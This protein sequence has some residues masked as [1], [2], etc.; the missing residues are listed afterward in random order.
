MKDEFTI[1]AT[2]DDLSTLHKLAVEQM[3]L[4]NEVEK[5]EKELKDVK[6]ELMK[7]QQGFLPDAIQNC[8]LSEFKT[9]RGDIVTVKDDMSVS[10][11]KTKLDDIVKWL[12]ENNHGDII[13]G[14]VYVNLPRNSHNERQAAIEALVDAGLEPSETMTVNTATLKSILSARLKRG[15]K[16]NLEDFG[17]FAW[18]KAIIKRV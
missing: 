1:E 4:E 2:E 9:Q 3:R 11:P 16:I 18:R 14:S 12:E 6:A 15:E 8:G 10:V 17:G 13:T 5:K 7:I